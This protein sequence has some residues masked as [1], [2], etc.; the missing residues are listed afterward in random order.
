SPASATESFQRGLRAAHFDR[1]HPG[2]REDAQ[3]DA[4]PRRGLSRSGKLTDEK[5]Y[6]ASSSVGGLRAT[7]TSPN[8]RLMKK[9][10]SD[11]RRPAY[12]A[13]RVDEAKDVLRRYHR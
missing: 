12:L 13:L 1:S 5:T 7:G 9:L 4:A 10:H 6:Q 3:D 2:R 11:Q 8:P